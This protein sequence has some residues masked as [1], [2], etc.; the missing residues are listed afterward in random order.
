MAQRTA[1]T[2]VLLGACI[3][4]MVLVA[5]ADSAQ[6]GAAAAGDYKPVASVHALMVGQDEQFGKIRELIV[7]E[8]A[9]DRFEHLQVAAEIL[10]EL[11]N[12]NAHRAEHDDYREWAAGARSASLEL[13]KAAKSKDAEQFKPLSK[14]IQIHCRDCHDKYH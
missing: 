14:Q 11:C 8:S 12:I 7:D 3:W 4:C 13:A 9:E 2:L 1:L 5:R 6:Q 10:A